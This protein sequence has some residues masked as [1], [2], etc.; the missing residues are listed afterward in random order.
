VTHTKTES[1][2]LS[3]REFIALSAPALIVV[4]AGKLKA[5]AGQDDGKPWYAVMRRCGQ[6]NFNE[7]D[8]LTMDTNAWADYWASL[9][10]DAVLLNGGGIVAFY[11]TQVPYHH[12]SE[13]LGSRDL[14]GEM[15]AASKKRNLRV[16]ARMDCNYTYEEALKAHPEWF[17]R[18]RDGSPRRHNESTWLY[19][20]CM[21]STYFTEQMPAIYREING[22]YPVDGFFTNGWP[23]AGPLSVCYCENCQKVYRDKVGGIPPGQTDATSPLYR[24]YYD[25]FMDRVLEVWQLW[26]AVAKERKPDSVYVGNLGGGI[27]TVKN[28]KRIGEVAGWFNADHQGRSGD[29]VIWDCAQQGRVAQ[30]V[31]KGRT[32]TNVTGSYSNS[33]PLWRHTAK[34]PAEATLW[35]A[36]TT[37]SGMVPWFHWLGGSPEDHRWREVG[38]SFFNWLAANE[39]HF[40]NRRSIADAAVLYP[41]NTIAFYKSGERPGAWRG[42][43]R[44]QTSDYLQGLYYAL[45]EGR[46]LFDFVHEEDLTPAELRKYRALLIPNA[47]YLSDKQCEQIRQYA[48]AGGSVLAT[49]ETSRYNEWGDARRDFALADLFGASVAGEI[50]GPHSNSYARIEQRHPVLKDFEGTALLPGAESRVPIKALEQSPLVLSVV[51]YYPAFPPEMVYA[52]TLR[53]DEPAAILRQKGNSRAAYFAGDIDRTFWRSGNTDLSQLIQNAVRWVLGDSRQPVS[54][55]GEGMTETFAWETA[56]GYALHIL[57]YTNPNMTRGFVR[58]FYAI[59]PQQV[60]FEVAAGKR[61]SSVRALH[62]GRALAFKQSGRT[63]SF[64]VPSV[65]D[66]EVIALT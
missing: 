9:K 21:F 42:A 29:T 46:F 43:E 28:V 45:L 54:V 26:D 33:R 4:S 50:I 3:R 31:M 39:P 61:I 8:P 10:V 55:T 53:T 64:E 14:F 11:P 62:A 36:Q 27:R 66:Y 65:V 1:L 57:N 25:V 6:I 59:G 38:R 22:R 41:Q 15:V 56:V 30:S 5:N 49:F 17:E 16:V 52:R 48:A 18:N 63:V 13:F 23:S 32:I 34:S 12:R 2:A 20:T 47:A 35:M 40:R 37:A 24:K 7:R 58:R 44:S 60:E 19:K 51:P